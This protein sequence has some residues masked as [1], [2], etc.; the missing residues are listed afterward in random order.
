M[1][2]YLV[3]FLFL[4]LCFSIAGFGGYFTSAS[5]TTWYVTLKK[6]LWNPPSWLFGP[7][8][9]LLYIF[10]AVSGWL[11]WMK[12]VSKPVRVVLIVYFI[13]IFFNAIWSPVFFGLHNPFLAF[14]IICFLWV[15][16]GIYLYLSW[17]ISLPAYILFIP[18]WA[19]V[20]FASILNFTIWR[21]NI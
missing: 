14:I 6:P 16:I 18:Y 7:V 11:V 12:G 15:S 20:T 19:W 3:L 5:V 9:T 1:K 4:L 17:S 10:I 13:Q 2:K 21:L 8:W